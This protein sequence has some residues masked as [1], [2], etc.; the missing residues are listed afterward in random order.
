[1]FEKQK[2]QKIIMH[3]KYCLNVPFQVVEVGILPRKT[4]KGRSLF[5]LITNTFTLPFKYSSL[6]PVSRALKKDMISL[7]KINAILPQFH[8]FYNNLPV[9]NDDTGHSDDIDPNDE[10][11]SDEEE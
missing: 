11:G 1:M 3:Y 10:I 5:D 6:L 4:R 2:H 7:C 8:A 9:M